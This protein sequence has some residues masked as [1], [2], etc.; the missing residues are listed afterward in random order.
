MDV[1]IRIVDSILAGAF[2]DRLFKAALE[3]VGEKQSNLVLQ[4]CDS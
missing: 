4:K 1:F 2:T 3:G